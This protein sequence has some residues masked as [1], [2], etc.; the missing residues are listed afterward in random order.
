MTTEYNRRRSGVRVLALVLCVGMFP[1]AAALADTLP[2]RTPPSGPDVPVY[3]PSDA[4]P[5]NTLPIPDSGVESPEAVPIERSRRET[6]FDRCRS[7]PGVG[8]GS[9]RPT[10][11]RGIPKR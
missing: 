3:R 8:D 9:N 5:L 2:L 7:M 1:E 4:R 11:C 6:I 10:Y